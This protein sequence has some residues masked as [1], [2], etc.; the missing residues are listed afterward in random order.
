MDFPKKKRCILLVDDVELFLELERTFFHRED[1][2]L[3][4]AINAKEIMQ[5]VL[6]RRPDLI[7]LDLQISGARGDDICRWLKKD[8]ELEKIPV[9][10]LVEAGDHAAESRCAQAGCNA[11]IHSPVKRT[12]LL[13]VARN[14]LALNDRM[15]ERVAKRVLVHFGTD[16]Q[17]LNSHFTVNLSPDGMF[18]A[19]DNIHPVGTRL[20]LQVQIPGQKTLGCHG[21]VAWLNHH[22]FSK[23]P[24]LPTGMG[25]QFSQL[26]EHHRE[27]VKNFLI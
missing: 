22:Q 25:I 17:H 14:M 9:I 13:N 27:Q 3:L 26:A 4:M 15:Q 21:E 16:P 6:E 1:F 10:M 18:L 12:Q 2:D 23:K 19:T 5:L 20:A 7:F 24:H 8:A 11:I